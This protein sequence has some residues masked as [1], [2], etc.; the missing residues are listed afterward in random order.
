MILDLGTSSLSLMLMYSDSQFILHIAQNSV[1]REH[2][3]HIKVDCNYVRDDLKDGLNSYFT[4]PC[5]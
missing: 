3:K 2:T 5:F 4:F 1:F